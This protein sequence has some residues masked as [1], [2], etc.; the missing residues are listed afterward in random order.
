ML[1]HSIRSG[2]FTES[3]LVLESCEMNFLRY[4]K[5]STVLRGFFPWCRVVC[6]YVY[7]YESRKVGVYILC[8][9]FLMHTFVLFKLMIGPK[10]VAASTSQF[11]GL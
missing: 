11:T 10:A 8:D 5:Y 6:A 4:V 9:A 2:V 3:R 7:N 1:L